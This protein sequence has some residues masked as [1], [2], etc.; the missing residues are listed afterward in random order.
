MKINEDYVERF[1][2]TIKKEKDFLGK[3][4]EKGS[5]IDIYTQAIYMGYLDACRTFQ[6]QKKVQ[7]SD[8]KVKEIAEEMK[9]YIEG[10]SDNFD[11]TFYSVCDGLCDEYKMEFG[12]AQKIINMAFKY[13]YCIASEDL[14][15]RFD[16]CHLPLDG[17]MLEWIHRN[18]PEYKNRKL[19][20]VPSWSK[21]EE[22][23]ENEDFTYRLYKKYVDGYCDE[24]VKT[25][26]QLD[27]E[28][29]VEMSQMLAAEEYIKTFSKDELKKGAHIE[30]LKKCK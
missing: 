26:L 8:D 9:N 22:G 24:N 5:P 15:N 6:N 23:S 11:K 28:N 17:I 7:K 10:N 20:K 30:L 13:L 25:P 2:E 29:W 12:Q 14:K 16:K 21:I 27:F 18:I 4:L 19:K 3:S 1:K